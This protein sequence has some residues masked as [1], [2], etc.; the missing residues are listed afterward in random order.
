MAQAVRG[1]GAGQRGAP[2]QGFSRTKWDHPR[3]PQC[4]SLISSNGAVPTPH[5][6]VWVSHLLLLNLNSSNYTPA[7]VMTELC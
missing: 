1:S 2:G 3:A 7:G 5:P 4:Y 6:D